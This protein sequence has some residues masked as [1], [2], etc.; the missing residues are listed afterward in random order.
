MDSLMKKTSIDF[1][2]KKDAQDPLSPF[3]QSFSFPKKSGSEEPV[4]YFAGRS[5]GLMPKK[6]QEYIGEECQAWA[7]YGV[8]GHF[9]SNHP[10]LSYHEL[11]TKSMAILLVEN[12]LKLLS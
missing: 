10:W 4:L 5:L 2:R 8:E 1:A 6:A 9:K 3:R 12:L 7:K 11:L